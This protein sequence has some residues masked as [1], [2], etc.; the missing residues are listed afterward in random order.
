MNDLVGVEVEVAVDLAGGDVVEAGDADRAGPPRAGPGCRARWCGRTGA[1]SS[2]ARL[3][4]DSA[5]KF[6]TT[7][8]GLVAQVRSAVAEVADVALDEADP[9]VE[10]VQV[11][12][13][14]GVGEQVVDDHAVVGCAPPSSGRS[15]S[16]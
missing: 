9:V 13:V 12:P 5:A 3:L 14:A 15:W 2:T 16:R 10:A 1:G 6:T 8:I 4:W 7:S 11:G